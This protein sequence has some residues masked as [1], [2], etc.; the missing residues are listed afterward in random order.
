[1]DAKV[2]YETL[3]CDLRPL[4]SETH[5]VRMTV[6]GEKLKCEGKPSSPIVSLLN[7]KIF[8]NSVISNAHKG[9]SFSNADIKNHYLQIPMKRYQYMCIPLKY[10][11]QEIKQEYNIMQ[12][13]Q[14][15]YVYIEIRK[16]MYGLKEAG[17]LAFNYLVENLVPHGYHPVQHTAVLWC[18]EKKPQGLYYVWIILV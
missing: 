17:I 8:L 10:F 13:A 16:G 14:D 9:A 2:T 15:G 1:M 6:G 11:T 18:H 4:K 5:R 3:I 7:K 12:I